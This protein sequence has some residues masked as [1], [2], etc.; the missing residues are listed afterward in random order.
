MANFY[1]LNVRGLRDERKRK[2]LFSFL[3]HKKYDIIF[4]QESHSTA[5]IESSWQKEW[6]GKICFSHYSLRAMG[7]MIMCND[8]ANIL[9]QWSDT[10]GHLNLIS[11]ELNNT[12]YTCINV[13]VPNIDWERKLYFENLSSSVVTGYNMASVVM[14][15]DFNTTL[16]INNKKFG[17]ESTQNSSK[18][19]GNLIEQPSLVEIWRHYYPNVKKFTWS[20]QCPKVMCRLD[21]FLINKTFVPQYKDAGILESFRTDHKLIFLSLL[22]D[23]KV[24]PR[25]PGF[26]KLNSSLLSDD[27]YIHLITNLIIDKTAEYSDIGD[28]RVRWDLL[29]FDVQCKSIDFSKLKS[30]KRRE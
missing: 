27:E 1:S 24:K 30:R 28:K 17:I 26:Y 15:G 23:Q 13:Y 29:K 22:N 7:T 3:K 21:M 14:A 20:R 4:I 5:E 8:K 9:S 11:V 25:G 16:T 2:E 10:E 18:A 12:E 6:G 19:L